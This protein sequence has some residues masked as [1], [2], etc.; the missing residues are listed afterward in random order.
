MTTRLALLGS[1]NIGGNRIKMAD[2]REKLSA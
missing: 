2:L 1:I